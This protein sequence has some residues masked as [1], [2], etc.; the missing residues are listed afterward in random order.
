MRN[1]ISTII[2]AFSA[3]FIFAQDVTIKGVISDADY[4]LIGA[5]V[6]V[7]TL[8]IGTTTDIDGSYELTVPMGTEVEVSYLGYQSQTFVIDSDQVLDVLMVADSQVLDEL[9]V[10]A[11]GNQKR[12]EISGA[13]GTI[14]A[15]EIKETPILRMEQA[16]QG[17]SA[18]VTV[19]QNSGSPGSALSVRIRGIGTLQDSN[20]LYVVD[21]VI[22]EGIDFLSPNDVASVSVLKDAASA[23]AYGARAA[24]GVVLIT[25]KSGAKVSTSSI[26]YEGYYGVQ[27]AQQEIDLLNANEY[28]VIWNE[29][30]INS[31]IVPETNL[32]NTTIFGEGNNWQSSLFENAPMQNHQIT[33]NGGQ[34]GFSY[35]LS[36]SLFEQQGIVGNEKSGY[37]RQTARLIADFKPKS[38]LKLNANIGLTNINN[39][40]II[41]NNQFAAPVVFA[42]N[43][44]PL[45]PVTKPDGTFA[46][47]DFVDTDIRN[48]LGALAT[49]FDETSANRIVGSVGATLNLTDHISVRSTYS[50]DVNHLNQKFFIPTFNLSVDEFDAPVQEINRINT[51]GFNNNR[52]RNWQWDNFLLY[53][54]EF[55]DHKLNIMVGTSAIEGSQYFNGGANTDLPSNDPDD[56]FI[57]NTIATIESQSTYEGIN[58]SAFFSYIGQAQYTFLDRYNAVFTFRRDG[59]SKFGPNNRYGNFFAASGSWNIDR[60]SFFNVDWVSS[61]KLRASWGQN[62]NDRIG[63]YSFTSVVLGGQNYTFGTDQSITNGSVAPTLANPDLKWETVTQ[64]NV[65][66][67][68][69]FWE[70]RLSLVADYYIKDTDDMLYLAPIL[71]VAGAAAPFQN[72]GKVRNS[73]F[74]FSSQY[75][76]RIGEFTYDIGGNISFVS[77]EVIDLAGGDPTIS[78]NIFGGAT[79]RT[80]VGHPIASFYG[81]VTDGIF[82]D[83]SEVTAHAFQNENTAPGD[84]RFADL[85]MDGIIDE[86]DQTFI[87]NP[88]P[89]ITYGFNTR[90][91]YGDFDLSLFFQG[92][93][94][95]EVY[96]A[97]VRYDKIGG[98]RPAS[99]LDRWTG[100][101]TSNFEPKVGVTD[102]NNNARISDRFIED[103][104]F[105]KL[106]NVQLGYN[107][108][109]FLD[110][111]NI[112]KFRVYLSGQNLY[113]WT[114]YSGF[115]PEVGAT[116]SLDLGIDRGFYPASRTILG[117]V[118]LTF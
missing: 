116:G 14:T 34:D 39:R 67:D 19:T 26:S 77:N 105:L 24:N 72:I 55:E 47:S 63:L 2:L 73:G 82:Q 85:N 32:Q 33:I 103:G 110:R 13:V 15:E 87:G 23:A 52:F 90:L 61:L 25:T 62:G 60:E 50:I 78:G 43:M 107:F 46:Y 36:G 88:T 71:T 64:T 53:D 44:D 51:V 41:E 56:A 40:G 9:V 6:N 75:R 102:P 49:T 109:N 66:V 17:R 79:S 93:Q 117:G 112:Q 98:N 38:Y 70:G 8:G 58:E 59:S 114:N 91:G 7:E 76:N 113:T 92:V 106:R 86:N 115:D 29:A 84:I 68:A 21:G 20:P 96:N 54:R 3:S 28:A 45:T 81:Y 99:I 35:G 89:D 83:Q 118:Q 12:S 97:W 30:Y 69:E 108:S 65:G 80:D 104:S 95:N 37:E 48:P 5:V 18:G 57:G 16:L 10:V 42:L 22:V 94:G 31:G 101:G 100:P 11:Y 74:E 111:W 4:P 1:F 27:S